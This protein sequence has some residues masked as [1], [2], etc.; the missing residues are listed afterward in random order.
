[1][2]DAIFGFLSVVDKSYEFHEIDLYLGTGVEKQQG[3]GS[4]RDSSEYIIYN[5]K[6]K[7]AGL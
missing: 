1:M 6:L 2:L 3:K 7:F 5:R 4:Y